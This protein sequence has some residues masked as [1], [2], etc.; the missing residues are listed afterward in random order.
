M[1][2]NKKEAVDYDKVVGQF[3]LKLN[4]IMKP[5]R[6][7]GQADYVD[8][9]MPVILRLALQLH[10]KLMGNDAPYSEEDLHW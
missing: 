6:M 8:Q 10:E 7:Y 1:S 3:K 2:E 4:G 9:A 5:V